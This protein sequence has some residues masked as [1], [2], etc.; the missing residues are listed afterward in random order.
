[1]RLLNIELSDFEYDQL[2]LN[3]NRYTLSELVEILNSK[4]ALQKLDKSTKLAKENGLSE[5]TMGE[6]DNEV[7]S[8][9]NAQ[10]NS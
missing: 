6:I 4:I 10:A 5:M 8:V 2:G 9:R 7:K 1:M 3:S